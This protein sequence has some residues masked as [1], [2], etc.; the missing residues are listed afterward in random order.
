MTL[1]EFLESQIRHW[2][3]VKKLEP[4]FDTDTYIRADGRVKAY[5]DLLL[6]CPDN[7]LNKRILDEVY[8]R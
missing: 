5:T 4:R 2:A 7:V 1:K 6:V 8:F 3:H